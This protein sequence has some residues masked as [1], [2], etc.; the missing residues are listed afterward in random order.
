MLRSNHAPRLLAEVVVLTLV[1]PIVISSR[2]TLSS[3]C[4]VPI[5]KNSVFYS[6]NLSLSFD[7]HALTALIQRSIDV[8]A[9]VSLNSLSG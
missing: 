5:T 6:F 8:I 9:S 2:D 3:C 4:R 1:C 7:I